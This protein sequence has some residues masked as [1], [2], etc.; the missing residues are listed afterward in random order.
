HVSSGT[1][2][3]EAMTCISSKFTTVRGILVHLSDVGIGIGIGKLLPVAS[4][5][6]ATSG[7]IARRVVVKKLKA[8]LFCLEEVRAVLHVVAANLTEEAGIFSL[9]GGSGK[10]S[11]VAK[12]SIIRM[13]GVDGVLLAE[14]V[15]DVLAS[16][17]G[18]NAKGGEEGAI[19]ILRKCT[20]HASHLKFA[21]EGLKGVAYARLHHVQVGGGA[22]GMESDLLKHLIIVLTD[23][24]ESVDSGEASGGFS[25]IETGLELVPQDDAIILKLAKRGLQGQTDLEPDVAGNGVLA[26]YVLFI[27]AVVLVQNSLDTSDDAPHSLL[28]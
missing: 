10:R 19:L 26:I 17:V 2:R 6:L 28:L 22:H 1:E 18:D 27:A 23:G 21:V 12:V 7:A 9:G 3:G 13:T 25:V 20:E 8:V 14:G 15:V 5:T 11:E 24:E 4:T 16:E